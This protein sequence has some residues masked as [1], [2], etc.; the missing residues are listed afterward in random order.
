L[1]RVSNLPTVWSNVL[2]ALA[3]SGELSLERHV[4]W[5]MLIFSIFYVGGMFLNDAFD[6][7][8][9][10]AQRPDRPIPSGQV[11]AGAVFGLGFGA[12]FAATLLS[13]FVARGTGASVLHATGSGVALSALIIFYDVY[14]KQNPVSPLVMGA[15]RVM[16]YVGAAYVVRD[17]LPA[18]VLYGALALW[19]YLIGL[20]YAAKQEAMNRLT[21]VWPLAFLAAPF[22]YGVSLALDQPLVWPWLGAF[23]AWVV[24]ALRF[25]RSGPRRSVPGAVVRLIAGIS[26]LDAMLIAGA[27]TTAWALV[28]VLMCGTTRLL[29]RVIPGT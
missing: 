28:A 18:S 20:T 16:I 17:D 8:I 14:H 19:C 6:R 10:K 1:G 13:A 25:L 29:Q 24:Y 11:S 12:L 26:L 5:V 3:L 4:L 21:R 2:A 7:H 23:A 22:A 27:G 9:D 15:C